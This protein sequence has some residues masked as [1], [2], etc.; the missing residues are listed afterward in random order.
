MSEQI[1]NEVIKSDEV[2][3]GRGRPSFPFTLPDTNKMTIND[4]WAKNPHFKSRLAIY[5]KVEKLKEATAGDMRLKELTD[6]V[7][8]SGENGVGKPLTVFMKYSAWK[9]SQ[10]SKK[11]ARTVKAQRKLSKLP[12]VDLADSAVTVPEVPAVV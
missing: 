5:Q 12:V 4:I 2:K 8:S 9:R 6:T 11:A 3:R 1:K 10:A 7:P